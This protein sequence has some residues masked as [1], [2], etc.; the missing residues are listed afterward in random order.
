MNLIV[1]GSGFLGTYLTEALIGDKMG[2]RVYDLNKPSDLNEKIE[3]IDGDVRNLKKLEEVTKG[4]EVIYHLVALLPQMRAKKKVMYDINVG[5][6][7]NVLKAAI[8]NKVRRI[9]FLSSS[10]VYGRLTEIPCPET[11]PL[12]PIGEYGRNKVECE[13]LCDDYIKKN[14]IEIVILRPTT[15]LGPKATEPLTLSLMERLSKKQSGFIL[16]NGKNKFQ[17]V[18]VK[19]VADACILAAKQ[20]NIN[21]EK[22]N[23]G[24]DSASS[25][26]DTIFQAMRYAGYSEKQMKV[27]KIP[28]RVARFFLGILNVFGKSPLEPDHYKLAHTDFMLSNLKA[29][30]LLNWQPKFDNFEVIKETYNW[31][32]KKGEVK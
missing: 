29:K 13:K 7:E 2:L 9:V 5:G 8:K 11:H 6:T 30:K 16:G 27:R 17:M 1:G 25:L 23:L 26:I 15:L 32:I 12:N 20:D 18:H 21:G 28:P 31:F 4:I 10:E 24:A 3:F 14:N 22:F 19:D